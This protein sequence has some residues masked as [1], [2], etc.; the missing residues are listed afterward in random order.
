LDRLTVVVDRN[1]LQAF[2]RTA[3]VMKL[4][5]LSEKWSAFGWE[6]R[7]IDGHHHDQIRAALSDLPAHEGRPTV[8]LARTV[9]GKGVSF[10]EDRLEWH[11][12]SPNDDDLRRALAELGAPR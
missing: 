9:K 3:E 11:Y 2:G 7:D 1:G 10:M 6:V 5:P 8:V 4:E 12:R